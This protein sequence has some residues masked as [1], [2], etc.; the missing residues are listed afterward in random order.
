[1]TLTQIQINE[2]NMAIANEISKQMGGNG[3]LKAMIGAKDF[4]AIENG[5][6]FKY[7]KA[8]Y[9]K[10]TLNGKDLYDVEFSSIR[11]G[12]QK[13]LNTYNDV[14]ATDLKGLFERETGLYLSL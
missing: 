6:A 7:P 3:K 13:V 9:V 1:M 10:I 8:K 12:K 14:Y 2:N 11:G 4:M 5:F